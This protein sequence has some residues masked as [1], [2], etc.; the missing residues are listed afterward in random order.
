MRPTILICLFVI[1]G[2]I[3]NAQ[4]TILPQLGFENSRTSIEFN[5][6][7]SFSPLA[8]KLLPQAAIRLD[9]K[10]KQAHGPFLGIA[11][12][13]SIVKIN[14]S[15][16]ETGMNSYSA[17]KGN[18]Q[19][20]LEGGYQVS[21]KPIYFKKSGSANK[22]SK[23]NYQKNTERKS[24]GSYMVRKSCGSKMNK[25]TAAKSKDNRSWVRIQPS[26]GVAYIPSAPSAEINTKSQGT[27]TSYEYN[28]GN[29]KTAL[30]SGVGFEF[31]KNALSKFNVSINYVKGMGN[32]LDTKSITTVSGNKSTTTTLESDASSWNLRMGIPINLNKK[33]PVIKQQI[34][35]KTYKEE[36]KCGQYKSQYKPRC[37]KV[38]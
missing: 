24:C 3:A 20:R 23:A 8:A 30:I 27:Q 36:K 1:F 5:E 25:A 10:F 17:S 9:Y 21:T 38:I 16:P 15:D 13:R 6:G 33:K 22:S 34:I 11:T 29:W 26:L 28:A 18:T 37:S 31:G 2:Y 19:L 4:F 12:S 35:E 32:N 7:S 14:F